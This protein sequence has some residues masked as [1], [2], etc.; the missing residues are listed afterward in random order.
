MS[1]P[2]GELVKAVLEYLTLKGCYAFR[3]NSGLTVREYKGKRHV[4]RAG[5]VGGADILGCTPD[6]RFL[7]IE[8][9]IGRNKPTPA[10]LDFLD[11]IWTR[12][13]IGIVVYPADYAE[14]I[15]KALAPR[16]EVWVEGQP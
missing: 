8:A 12:G 1:T 14:K 11:E 5:V 4:I 13:G 9:K 3:N 6:G 7:A 15:D 10:Q 16:G 2:E